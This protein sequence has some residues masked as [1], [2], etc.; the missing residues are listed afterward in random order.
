MTISIKKLAWFIFFVVFFI[1]TILGIYFGVQYKNQKEINSKLYTEEQV[2]EKY[3]TYVEQIKNK[4]LT[5]EELNNRLTVY[6]EQLSDA[7]AEKDEL[8]SKLDEKDAKISELNETIANLEQQVS[9][10]NA[11]ITSLQ[12]E[13]TRLNGLLESY[14]DLRTGTYEVNFYIGEKLYKT[15]AVRIGA[16]ISETIEPEFSNEYR[17]DGWSLDG[18]NVI[19]YK[20]ITINAN[21]TFYAVTTQK[22]KVEF[23]NDGEIY[24][25]Q[26]VVK[27]DMA[28][29]IGNPTKELYR[30]VGWTLD[31][32]NV[33]DC[34]NTSVTE[35]VKYYALFELAYKWASLNMG[36]ES[37]G[38]G[39]SRFDDNGTWTGYTSP[40]NGYPLK[41][42]LANTNFYDIRV[43]L[44]FRLY[45]EVESVRVDKNGTIYDESKLDAENAVHPVL[46]DGETFSINLKSYNSQFSG[47]IE[48]TV[49]TIK[50]SYD[51]ENL[52]FNFEVSDSNK[53]Y[54]SMN[55]LGISQVEVL[56][57]I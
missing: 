15:K 11:Q 32:T 35:D 39:I 1:G 25:T 7:K 6:V 34:F 16:Q 46:R 51:K 4:N 49:L 40:L 9:E 29:N 43:T 23:F 41:D 27:G 22:F 26:Y 10:I 44:G 36:E 24:V 42:A 33:V 37:L 12:N 54:Y 55:G 18:E 30:F 21:T 2:E 57:E 14:E 56:V 45:L 19:D 28:T 38:F 50:F 13:I 17:F 5:I 48:E 52:R 47:V 53:S 3:R 20:N 31:K 8:Q